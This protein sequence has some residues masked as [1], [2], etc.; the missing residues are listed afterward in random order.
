MTTTIILGAGLAGL[1][2]ARLLSTSG[3]KVVVIDRGRAVGGRMATHRIGQARLDHGAQFFT[4][5]GDL[6]KATVTEAVNAGAVVEWCRG[7]AVEDGFPRYRGSE[8]MA[9]FATWL[10]SGLNVKLGVD[11]DRIETDAGLV[12]FVGA[13]GELLAQGDQAIV[14]TPIP[15]M[16]NLFDRGNI[17]A[18]AE[19][20]QMLR[21]T[22]YFATL[23]L[24]V[25]VDGQPDIDEPGGMQLDDGPY[26]FI[27]DN[28]RKG[29]SAGAGPHFPCRTRLQPPDGST[30][31]Q[32]TYLL[33]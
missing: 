16:L 19:L 15:Q 22:S 30:T 8:G 7:F 23:A 11:V 20:D 12:R 17:R 13:K 9:S 27:A 31:I 5:R 3:H 24:L 29:I 14:T 21:T 33:T 18:N 1:T 6:F 4:T 10:A 2:A 32:M 26:T 28:H 25:T